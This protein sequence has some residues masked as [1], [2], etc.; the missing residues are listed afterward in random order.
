MIS[1]SKPVPQNRVLPGPVLPGSV[2]LGFVPLKLFLWVIII[3]YIV[4]GTPLFAHDDD[5][6]VRDRQKPYRGPGWR[7]VDGKPI[8]GSVAGTF[9][10]NGVTLRSWLPLAQLSAPSTSA[11]SCWGYISPAGREYAIIGL[12]DGTAF[13]DITNPWADQPLARCARLPQLLLRRL[14]G[15]Q[16]RASHRYESA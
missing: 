16:R 5:G 4:V 1:A 8:E 11:N 14:R 6:K 9:D 7:E 2:F 10:S 12:S 15:R 3:A 13:V